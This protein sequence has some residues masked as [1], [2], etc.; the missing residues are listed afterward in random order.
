VLDI[1]YRVKWVCGVSYLNVPCVFIL[2]KEICNGLEARTLWVDVGYIA[3]L[4]L[5]ISEVALS[6]HFFIICEG[7]A[8]FLIT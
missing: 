6:L 5:L 7:L 1:D 4:E 2:C 8:F 3:I